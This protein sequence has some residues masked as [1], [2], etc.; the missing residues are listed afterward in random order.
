[1]LHLRASEVE[2]EYPRVEDVM[3]DR[4]DTK[5]KEEPTAAIGLE[6]WN[7]ADSP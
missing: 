1:M 3:E 5:G 6:G 4:D 2:P 7:A